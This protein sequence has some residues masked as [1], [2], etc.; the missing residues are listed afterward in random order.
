MYG[1]STVGVWFFATISAQLLYGASSHVVCII[2]AYR[3]SVTLN[4]SGRARGHVW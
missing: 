2:S 1:E 3:Q 4:M